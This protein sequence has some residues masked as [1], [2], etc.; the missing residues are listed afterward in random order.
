MRYCWCLLM[1][2]WVEDDELD[3]VEVDVVLD[4]DEDVDVLLVL[5]DELLLDVLDV[6]LVLELEVLVE[7]VLLEVLVEEVELVDVLVDEVLLDEIL[8][9]VGSF[10]RLCSVCKSGIFRSPAGCVMENTS[11]KQLLHMSAEDIGTIQHSLQVA[12]PSC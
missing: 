9:V 6:L 2:C 8:V 12:T 3:D 4:E 7:E 10:K 5:V 11:I 1:R